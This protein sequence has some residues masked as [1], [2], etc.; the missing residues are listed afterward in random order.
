MWW[1]AVAENREDRT[2]QEEQDRRRGPDPIALIAG[3][4]ALFGS[5]YILTDGSWF[6][7]LDPRW[8][9]AGAALLVGALLL[10]A[11]TR[12]GKRRG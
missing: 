7:S 4:A 9:I 11:S 8:M 5:A 10:A 2:V 1:Y 3:V 12:S 6:P